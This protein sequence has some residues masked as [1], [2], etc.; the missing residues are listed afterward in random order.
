M[1]VIVIASIIV[2]IFGT[3]I[4]EK[5]EYMHGNRICSP[6]QFAQFFQL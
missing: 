1:I 5:S 3:S 4:S 2:I 6:L